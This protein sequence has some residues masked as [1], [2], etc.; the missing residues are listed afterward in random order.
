MTR[1]TRISLQVTKKYDFYV[2]AYGGIATVLYIA[3]CNQIVK[4]DVFSQMH[5]NRRKYPALLMRTQS[6]HSAKITEKILDF[7]WSVLPHL[8]YSANL[9]PSDYHLFIL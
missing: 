8:P 4:A 6:P 3:N 1:P 5:K 7:I 2:N 9:A